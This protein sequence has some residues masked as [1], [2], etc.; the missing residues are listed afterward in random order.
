MGFQSLGMKR[1]TSFSVC[2]VQRQWKNSAP[3]CGSWC[4]TTRGIFTDGI[5]WNSHYSE[6]LDPFVS[7]LIERAVFCWVKSQGWIS[8]GGRQKTKTKQ[9]FSTLLSQLSRLCVRGCLKQPRGK[10]GITAS[11]CCPHRACLLCAGR[12]SV[13]LFQRWGTDNRLSC[14]EKRSVGFWVPPWA[15]KA[16]FMNTAQRNEISTSSKTG[17]T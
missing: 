8:K 14:H 10:L 2:F 16:W 17:L 12:L 6:W 5:L 4:N 13:C 9:H 7:L 11:L 3:L 15:C 1:K